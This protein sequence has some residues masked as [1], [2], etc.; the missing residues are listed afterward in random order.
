MKKTRHID[1]D[2]SHSAVKHR[3]LGFSD[4]FLVGIM[5]GVEKTTV[6]VFFQQKTHLKN[7]F[8]KHVV[9]LHLDFGIQ[10]TRVCYLQGDL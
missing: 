7:M 2:V 9:L 5:T 3:A 1:I 10:K 6:L 8:M 4:R